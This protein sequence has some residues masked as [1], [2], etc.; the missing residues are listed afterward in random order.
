MLILSA[1][2]DVKGRCLYRYSIGFIW[3]QATVLF[4]I[5][6]ILGFITCE[7]AKTLRACHHLR[8]QT[9]TAFHFQWA[10]HYWMVS[11]LASC[12][13]PQWVILPPPSESDSEALSWSELFPGLL[14][15]LSCL[16]RP[17]QL[18]LILV[19]ILVLLGCNVLETRW[20]CLN[21]LDGEQGFAGA[22]RRCT[23]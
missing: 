3:G 23:P 13:Y 17:L 11:T 15:P 1:R 4:P 8:F 12:N 18:V 6:G 5:L 10:L 21:M 14:T 20:S 19:L 2:D 22:L 9:Q 7:L 16:W